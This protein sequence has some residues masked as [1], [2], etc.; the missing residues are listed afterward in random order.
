L[1][2]DARRYEGLLNDLGYDKKL[3]EKCDKKTQKD[4]IMYKKIA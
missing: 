3:P 4:E 2:W 1:E